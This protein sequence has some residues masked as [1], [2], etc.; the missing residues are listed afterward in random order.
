MKDVKGWEV[1]TYYGIPIYND[2][3]NKYPIVPWQEYYT[4]ARPGGVNAEIRHRE[5]WV[6]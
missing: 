3:K 5:W 6:G 4:H 2:V 1:G